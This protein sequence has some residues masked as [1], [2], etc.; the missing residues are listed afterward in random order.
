MAAC[1]S[2]SS[3]TR[4]MMGG[5]ETTS[6]SSGYERMPSNSIAEQT[7]PRCV[8]ARHV[9]LTRGLE[10]VRLTLVHPQALVL[11]AI[12]TVGL[13]ARRLGLGAGRRA[14][15]ALTGRRARLAPTAPLRRVQTRLR[16]RH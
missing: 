12:P 1:S 14:P 4:D 11:P 8:R 9:T 15:L 16:L 13:W 6:L 10:I 7:E 3:A 5:V 2:A